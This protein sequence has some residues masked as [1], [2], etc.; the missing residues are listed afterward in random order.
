[1]AI[2]AKPQKQS[3]PAVDIDQ[4][5]NRGGSVASPQ[6]E[7]GRDE[8][9]VKSVLLRVPTDILEIVDSQIKNRRPRIS[10]H[11][12]ILESIVQRTERDSK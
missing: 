6:S 9:E 10:R 7:Q 4:L 3:T 8:P 11:Q 2:T 1:M 5:I 12:W